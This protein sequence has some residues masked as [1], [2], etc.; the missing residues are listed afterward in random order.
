MDAQVAT[1][2]SSGAGT[3]ITLMTTDAWAQAKH[4]FAALLG[5]RGGDA[6]AVAGELDAARAE[7]VTARNRGEGAVAA[8]LGTEW[9]LRLGRMLTQDPDSVALL[10][11]LVERYAPLVERINTNTE[12]VGNNFHGTVAIH[13]GSG[14]QTN[15][16]GPGAT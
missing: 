6:E 5:R 2:A 13:T 4:A 15:T 12:I 1:L 14:N 3:L 9:R 8:D 11:G 7:L 16:F 10:A